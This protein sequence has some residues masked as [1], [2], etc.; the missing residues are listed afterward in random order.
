MTFTPSSMSDPPERPSQSGMLMGTIVSLVGTLLFVFSAGTMIFLWVKLLF[1]SMGWLGVIV[2]VCTAPLGVAYP[3]LHWLARGEF[4]MF[5]F[6]I[7]AVGI[8]GLL[9][10]MT[11]AAWGRYHVWHRLPL[12]RRRRRDATFAVQEDD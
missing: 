9:V 12:L 10:S 7:W 1:E 11:W 6:A 3:F 5:F 2:G 4:P 8:V